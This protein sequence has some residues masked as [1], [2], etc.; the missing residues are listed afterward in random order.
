LFF[1]II[2]FTLTRVCRN[3]SFPREVITVKNIIAL[4]LVMLSAA[5]LPALGDEFCSEN[6]VCMIMEREDS[7]V[8][9]LFRNTLPIDDQVTTVTFEVRPKLE[10][11]SCPDRFPLTMTVKGPQAQ[12]VTTFT[13]IDPAQRWNTNLYFYWQYG[14]PSPEKRR[15]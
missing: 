1:L 5:A 14:S 11:L 6:K 2:Y 8:N 9:V 7:R 13:I 3:H 12:P 4:I 15:R 10:N